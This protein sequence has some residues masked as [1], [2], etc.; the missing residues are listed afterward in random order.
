MV[1]D[2]GVGCGVAGGDE[3]RPTSFTTHRSLSTP[4]ACRLPC[5]SRRS[6][7][8]QAGM[9][10]R[11]RPCMRPLLR[12]GG[13]RIFSRRALIVTYGL[14]PAD[15]EHQTV[16]QHPA[17]FRADC[18]VT[19]AVR[20]GGQHDG[21]RPVAVRLD[22][23]LPT[24]IL[25]LLQPPC[26]HHLATR[27]RERVVPQGLVAEAEFLAESELEGELALPVMGVR[28]VVN[29]AASLGDGASL[30]DPRCP[31]S[32]K[33]CLE[34]LGDR[35]RRVAGQRLLVA[36]ISSVKVTLTLM[37]LPRSPEVRV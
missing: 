37:V 4:G 2:A 9:P 31:S 8:V 11:G 19:G 14:R 13:R 12:S 24:D 36:R 7:Q 35:R 3:A 17:V 20:G 6:G 5:H 32:V 34:W 15:G 18:A 16:G 29:G 28:R 23:Y 33:V 1:G 10:L 25:A 22:G 27:H 21:H 30:S 26:L